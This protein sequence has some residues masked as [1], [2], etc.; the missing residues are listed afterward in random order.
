MGGPFVDYFCADVE[1]NKLI[2]I[3]GYVFAPTH[4]DKGILV[5]EV[6]AVLKSFIPS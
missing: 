1:N 5:R 2:M 4:P 6:E 3:E